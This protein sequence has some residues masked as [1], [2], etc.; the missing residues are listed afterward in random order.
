MSPATPSADRRGEIAAGLATVQQRLAAACAAAGRRRDELVLVVVSKTWPASDVLLG[1]DLGVRDVAENKD[2]EAV[3]KIAK[4][5]EMAKISKMAEIADLADLRW[6]FVGQLQTNK[7]RSV[8]TYADLVHSLDRTRLARALSEGAT[9]AGR[10]LDVLIQ[11]ALDDSQGRGGVD[12][13]GLWG[14]AETAAT[15]PGLRVA[16]L[17]GLAP[18]QGPPVRAFARLHELSVRLQSE[19]PGATVLSAGMSA[20]LE[21]AVAAGA[22]HLRVGTAV[23]GHRRPTLR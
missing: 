6:H 5:A 17:M 18:L 22:T 21:D 14:L 13:D 20:D 16:G 11:V 10:E 2:Q 23:F 15:L 19:H 3:A 9:R 7:A 1:Y 8:A 4:M 12:P